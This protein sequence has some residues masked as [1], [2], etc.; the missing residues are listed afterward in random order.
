MNGPKAVAAALLAGALLTAPAARAQGLR[1]GEPFPHFTAQDL[2]GATVDT[3]TLKGK[4]ILIDFW[5]IYCT[6]CIQEMPHIVALYTKYKDK[7]LAVIGVDLDVYGAARVQKF[8][9]GLD[10]PMPYPNIIDAKMQIKGILRV[11]M[12]P[13]TIVVDPAGT[14]RLF[15]VGY[16]PGFERELE[17]LVKKLLPAKQAT[18]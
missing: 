12:L 9:A 17:E 5:S 18:P 16:K 3:K 13:T 10:F 8:L 1:E 15:H 6:S 2:T 7:G 4:V 11:S 14:V